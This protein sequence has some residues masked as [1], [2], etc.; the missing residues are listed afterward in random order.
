MAP[1]RRPS[2]AR[3]HGQ[4]PEVWRRAGAPMDY[5]P[6]S[7]DDPTKTLRAPRGCDTVV[8]P[9]A[10]F[11]AAHSPR[12]RRPEQ[13]ADQ[14]SMIARAGR[15]YPSRSGENDI[16]RWKLAS[17]ETSETHKPYAA[18]AV[19]C[20]APRCPVVNRAP[21][22]LDAMPILA[23]KTQSQPRAHERLRYPRSP[24]SPKIYVET[25]GRW[26]WL[27]PLPPD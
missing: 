3:E 5:P 22:A 2:A 15:L 19:W 12:R 21:I 1:S 13:A 24:G 25:Q 9:T 10:A 7:L 6:W 20:I 27:L 26:P 16:P 8:A 17:S 11:R 23:R 4:L 18:H 14:T